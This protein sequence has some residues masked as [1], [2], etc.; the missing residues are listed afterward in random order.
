[1][2]PLKCLLVDRRTVPPA[3]CSVTR[4]GIILKDR[5]NKICFKTTLNIYKLFGWLI[6]TILL[7]KNYY[8]YILG[9]WRKDWATFF[10]QKPG[11]TSVTRLRGKAVY[12]PFKR[13]SLIVRSF[14]CL[15]SVSVQENVQRGAQVVVTL[16][17]AQ[18]FFSSSFAFAFLSDD[19]SYRIWLEMIQW[20]KSKK[21]ILSSVLNNHWTQLIS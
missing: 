10:S 4:V 16:Q 14:V 1:M 5:R 12:F 20:L 7:K 9:I 11:H 19:N 6:K 17:R 13:N 2:L 18:N 3:W 21:E 8:G 15:E